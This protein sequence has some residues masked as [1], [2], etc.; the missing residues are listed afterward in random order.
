MKHP[1]LHLTAVLLIVAIFVPAGRAQ[2][3][4]PPPIV[5]KEVDRVGAEMQKLGDWD[6]QYATIEKAIDRMWKE[7]GWDNE[8]DLF[9]REMISKVAKIPPW[10]FDRRLEVMQDS[11]RDRYELNNEQYARFTGQ[12]YREMGIF[13]FRHG[14][15]IYRHTRE[16]VNARVN[17][18]PFTPEQVAQ[19]TQESEKIMADFQETAARFYR[20][21]AEQLSPRQRA[22]LERDFESFQR[23]MRV[24]EELRG[25]WAEGKWR[26]EDW[27]ME[28]DP[29]QRGHPPLPD[30]GKPTERRVRRLYTPEDE[31]SWE[32]YVRIFIARYRLDE[33]QA[34]AALSILHELQERAAEYRKT[35]ADELDLIPRGGED[36]AEVYAPLRRLFEEL[37]RRLQPIPTTAQRR[38]VE[39]LTPSQ[40]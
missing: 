5:D 16:A 8:A 3:S 39:M 7:H 1:R 12:M 21:Q 22:I 35:H 2:L 25:Q 18:E 27:A 15:T 10:E 38:A 37:E 29:I 31:T 6:K 19:W 28:D 40:D 14:A 23:R 34:D 32:R 36:A 20:D 11:L 33:A 4:E 13:L 24:M 17:G 26:P 9:A 30:A